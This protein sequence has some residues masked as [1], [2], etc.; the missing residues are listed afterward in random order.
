[1]LLLL[2][3]LKIEDLSGKKKN[4]YMKSVKMMGLY[5]GLIICTIYFSETA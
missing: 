1:M 5:L 3:E 4:M 2:G